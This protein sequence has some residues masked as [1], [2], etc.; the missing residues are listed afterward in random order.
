MLRKAAFVNKLDHAESEA[1]ETQTWIHFAEEC[2]YLSKEAGHPSTL[3][4]LLPCSVPRSSACYNS[5]HCIGAKKMGMDQV[6]PVQQ[7]LDVIE[8]LSPEERLTVIE[9][10][11]RRWVDERREEIAR[12]AMMTLQ[13]VRERRATYGTVAELK[14]D[15]T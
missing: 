15:L 8:R 14:Q 12:N 11:Q 3:A 7:A 5:I 2:G 6:S 13:A 10:M 4:P 9:V 1:A